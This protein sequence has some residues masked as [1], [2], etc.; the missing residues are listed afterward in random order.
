MPHTF[1]RIR[2]SMMLYVS[3]LHMR[4]IDLPYL[5]GLIFFLSGPFF[6]SLLYFLPFSFV[7]RK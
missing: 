4:Y 5:L 2:A 6:P 7:G 3:V 1:H